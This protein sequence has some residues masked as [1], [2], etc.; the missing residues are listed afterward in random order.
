[1]MAGITMRIG[2]GR[3]GE[4]EELAEMIRFLAGPESEYCTGDVFSVSGGYTG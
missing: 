1:M 2:K 3:L 4:P